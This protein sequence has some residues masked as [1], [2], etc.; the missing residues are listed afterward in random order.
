[1]ITT[2]IASQLRDDHKTLYD[3][4][5]ESMVGMVIEGRNLRDDA[6]QELRDRV[7]GG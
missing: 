1:M 2:R 6:R 4:M 3:V 5:T 7:L